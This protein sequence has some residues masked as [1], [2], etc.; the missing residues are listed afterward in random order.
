MD[1]TNGVRCDLPHGPGEDGTREQ[2]R[3]ISRTTELVTMRRHCRT[4]AVLPVGHRAEV[5]TG[6]S[7][8]ETS[9][10]GT[11]IRSVPSMRAVDCIP[12][13]KDNIALFMQRPRTFQFM[14]Q[15]CTPGALRQ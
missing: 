2:Q 5:E 12:D 4:N 8:A 11:I 1:L 13:I 7:F 3:Q 15:P 10:C 14:S 6:P 9:F